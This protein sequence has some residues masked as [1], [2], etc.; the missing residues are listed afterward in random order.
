MLLTLLFYL[1][2]FLSGPVSSTTVDPHWL[3]DWAHRNGSNV[4]VFERLWIHAPDGSGANASF[5]ALGASLVDFWVHDR[6]GHP[7]DIVLGYD[8][9]TMYA[10]DPNYPFF[11]AIVGRYANRLAN[12]SYTDPY[13]HVEHIYANEHGGKNTLH[14]GM[15]GYSRAGWKVKEHLRSEITFELMDEGAE[16]FPGTVL[17]RVTYALTS[18]S[19]STSQS[20]SPSV[21]LTTRFTSRV[22]PSPTPS[23]REPVTPILLSSH[24]YF[25]LDGYHGVTAGTKDRGGEWAGSTQ[26][27]KLWVDGGK[28]VATDGEPVRPSSSPPAYAA[29]AAARPDLDLPN[30]PVLPSPVACEVQIPTGALPPV[31]SGSPLDFT[32]AGKESTLIGKQLEKRGAEGLCGTGCSGIDNALIFSSTSRDVGMDPVLQLKSEAS[33]IRLTIRTDQP[34]VHLYTCNSL[35]TSLSAAHASA[36]SSYPLHRFLRKRSHLPPSLDLEAEEA[37]YYPQHSCLAIEPEGLIDAVHHA[38][39]WGV[40]PWYTSEREY[41]WWTAYDFIADA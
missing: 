36:N 27:H 34:A 26:G 24:L 41:S 37:G 4:N 20:S 11:G 39:E 38:K 23:D 18:P 12:A 15:W 22:L 35:T 6:A 33:G 17:T 19:P 14:G 2:A 28:M 16:G 30:P 7:R 25:N 29:L 32:T 1:A 10:S 8:N 3:K 13:G 31:A 40:D 9:T 21:R 5:I